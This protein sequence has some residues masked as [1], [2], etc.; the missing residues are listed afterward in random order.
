MKNEY[1]QKV[2]LVKNMLIFDPNLT[3]EENDKH[4]DI[5]LKT[6][7]ELL[8]LQDKKILEDL[9]E[10]FTNENEEYGGFCEH[11]ESEIGNLYSLNQILEVLYVKFVYLLE[12]DI[13]RALHFTSWFLYNKMFDKFR[14][15]FSTTKPSK[16]EEFVNALYSWLGTDFPREIAILKKDIENW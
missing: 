1:K 8:N 16:A 7:D 11:L 3:E 2:K 10:L 15:M 12:N 6:T 4:F 13:S 14:I 9:L 5:A